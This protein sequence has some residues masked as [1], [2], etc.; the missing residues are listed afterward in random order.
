MRE[1][2]NEVAWRVQPLEVGSGEGVEVVSQPPIP[3]W[4]IFADEGGVGLKLA[5]VLKE[6]GDRTLIVSAG[7][8]YKQL[9]SEHFQINPSQPEEFVRLLDEGLGGDAVGRVV[10]LWGLDQLTSHTEGESVASAVNTC[11]SVLHLVQALANK[12]RKNSSP[13]LWLVTKGAQSVGVNNLP[14]QVQQSPLW[15]LGRVIAL[16]HPELRC[17]RLDLDPLGDDESSL[18]DEVLAEG[19]EDQVGYREGVRYVARLVRY[20]SQVTEAVG[21]NEPF[22]V[23]IS[24]YGILENLTVKPMT[25]RLPGP[26]EVEVQVRA[27]G[28]NFR[29]VLNAL[30]MLREYTEQMGIANALDLPF[31]GECAGLVVAVGENVSHLKVGDEVIAAQ[32]IGSLASH[33][34]ANAEFVV[35]KPQQLSFEEA[36]TIPTTFLTAREI[37]R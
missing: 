18:V 37:R 1:L 21:M 5:K 25:R 10:Y 9:E 12:A 32:T 29:D 15:G 33:V 24:D 34:I 30:G 31:G 36:A 26:G 4:L 20:G 8:V 23:K 3:S 11:G 7:G 22:Q 35:L 2:A 6:R 28:L 13:R 19:Q 16:E 14:L 27:V 17:V